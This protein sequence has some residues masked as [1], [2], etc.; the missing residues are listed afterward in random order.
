MSE[1]TPVTPAEATPEVEAVAEVESWHDPAKVLRLALWSRIAARV[2]LVLVVVTL[3][4]IG[5][6]IVSRAHGA[7]LMDLVRSF[8]GQYVGF[9]SLFMAVVF[10]E[11]LAHILEILLDI[12]EN[13]RSG[14]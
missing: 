13:T 8:V 11:G 10:F 2:F 5:W 1:Q 14:K 7:S 6:D 9:A 3:L 4:M 12:E